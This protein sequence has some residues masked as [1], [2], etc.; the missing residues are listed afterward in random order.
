LW[1]RG[2]ADARDSVGSPH[3]RF[4]ALV[5]IGG[6]T[7]VAWAENEKALS[8]DRSIPL[9][10]GPFLLAAGV[11]CGQRIRARARVQAA[12]QKVLSGKSTDVFQRGNVTVASS[13]PERCF[14]IVTACV[15]APRTVPCWRACRRGRGS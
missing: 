9:V 6:D 2:A 11:R 12:I 1:L 13:P 8:K 10:S 15:P 4:V 3:D 7:V 5:D 14:S